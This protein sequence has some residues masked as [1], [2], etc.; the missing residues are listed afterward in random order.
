MPNRM[1][2]FRGMS[3]EQLSLA[4]KDTEKHLFQLRF[5]SA[6]DRLETPSEIRK[7]RRDIARI[8][9]LQRE[10]ELAKLS[11]LST[12]QLSVRI[13]S[14][15]AKEDAGL[16]GKRTAHRQGARLKRFYVAKGGT[17]PIAPPAP[18]A[19]AAPAASEKKTDA[20]KSTPKGSGK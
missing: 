11:G 16:P 7:A 10:K 13:A 12:E 18:A 4:L 20:K 5:Q 9:T 19:P 17:L 15:Q 1:K 2:E 6:T 3:D 14:L 8:R